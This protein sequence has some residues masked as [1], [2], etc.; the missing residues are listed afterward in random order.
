VTEKEAFF[1]ISS[2]YL[3]FVRQPEGKFL[4]KS[5]GELGNELH[6]RKEERDNDET[7]DTTKHDDHDRLEQA[8]Q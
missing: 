7:D 5:A 8:H 4:T 3:S 6:Q 2:G 1:L